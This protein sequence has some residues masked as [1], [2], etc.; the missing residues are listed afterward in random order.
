MG[1]QPRWSNTAGLGYHCEIWVALPTCPSHEN[2]AGIFTRN[3]VVMFTL[4]PGRMGCARSRRTMSGLLGSGTT[5]TGSPF[6]RKSR[7]SM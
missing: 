7:L 2:E 1:C 5:F 3:G 4:P 6:T